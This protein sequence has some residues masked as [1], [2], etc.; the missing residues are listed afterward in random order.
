MGIE[1]FGEIEIEDGM[2]I[3]GTSS[4]AKE[5]VLK[6]Q[7]DA[8]R[9]PPLPRRLITLSTLDPERKEEQSI[10]LARLSDGSTTSQGFYDYK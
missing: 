5:P 7:Y 6:Q 9:P 8:T 10:R 3:H 4:S 1:Y 2:C